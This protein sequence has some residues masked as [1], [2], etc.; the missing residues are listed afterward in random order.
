MQVIKKF[1][2]KINIQITIQLLIIVFLISLNVIYTNYRVNNSQKHYVTVATNAISQ[3]FL[4][5]VIRANLPDNTYKNLLK[6]F[7]KTLTKIIN[8]VS[9]KNGFIILKQ[10]TVLTSLPDITVEVE[11]LVWKDMEL[12]KL[13]LNN[14]KK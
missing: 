9:S 10:N 5:S 14:N 2:K 4:A 11:G 12:D 13:L 1:I 8:N 6:T 3:R 7:D